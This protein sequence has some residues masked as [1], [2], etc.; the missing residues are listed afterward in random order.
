AAADERDHPPRAARGGAVPVA[1]EPDA[2][3]FAVVAEPRLVARARGAR[4]GDDVRRAGEGDPG[5]GPE[6]GRRQPVAGRAVAA[7]EREHAEEPAQAPGVEGRD[8]RSRRRRTDH[9]KDLET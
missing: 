6:P 8:L 5:A 1:L 9:P 7:P 3:A 2:P 4:R